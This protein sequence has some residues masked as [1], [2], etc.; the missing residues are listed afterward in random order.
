MCSYASDG[1]AELLHVDVLVGRVRDVDR[2]GTE[3][4]RR[5]PAAEQRNVGRVRDGRDL[6]SGDRVEVLRGDVRA[7]TRAPPCRS[8]SAAAPTRS[9]A[10][11]LT[12]RNISSASQIAG[13]MFASVPPRIVP[14]LYGRLA[15]DGILRQVDCASTSGSSD[16][17]GSMAETPRC[18]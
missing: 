17:I 13:T 6:E 7:R 9:G 1:G 2:A 16:S 5:A 10:T 11:S 18:G 12:S 3:E 4:Q 8:P 15:E 14:M